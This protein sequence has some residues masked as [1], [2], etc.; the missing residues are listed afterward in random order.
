MRKLELIVEGEVVGKARPRV[1]RYGAYTPAKTKN[2][3]RAI[4]LAFQNKYKGLV[5][6]KKPLRMEIDC[7]MYIPK[8]TSNIRR[9]R[10]NAKEILPD[11]KPDFDNMA[12]SITDALNGL[13]YEDDNQIV[14][15]RIRKFFSDDQRAEIRIAEVEEEGI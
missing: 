3:E 7:Y 9:K 6:L 2:Y 14:D 5:P 10:K 4:Q 13:A 8:N 11:K 1:T 12:K 15:A